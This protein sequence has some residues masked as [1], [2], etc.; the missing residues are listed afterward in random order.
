MR[1]TFVWLSFYLYCDSY[2]FELFQ[3]RSY[4][5]L[6]SQV[7]T[8]CSKFFTS[9]PYTISLNYNT[10]SSVQVWR[11]A[12]VGIFLKNIKTPC[13]LCLAHTLITIAILLFLSSHSQIALHF[14]WWS[15][16]SSFVTGFITHFVSMFAPLNPMQHPHDLICRWLMNSRIGLGMRQTECRHQSRNALIFNNPHLHVL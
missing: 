8:L 1:E 6:F 9:I 4:Y 13:K 5:P 2:T 16:L 11:V 14:L 15:R 10:T 3:F 12:A 7:S